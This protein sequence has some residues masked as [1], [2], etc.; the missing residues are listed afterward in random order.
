[1]SQKI[2]GVIAAG[3][4]KTAEAG[5]EMF[6]LGGNAFDA[7]IASILAAFVVESALTS[8]A[9]GGFLLAHTQDNRNILFDFFSQTPR[10]KKSLEA[11]N[12]YPIDVNFG[13]EMQAFHIGLGSIAVPGN[14]AGVFK[15]QQQLGRLPFDIV[16]QPAIHYAQ[17]GFQVSNFQ[18]FCFQLLEPILLALPEGK[19]IY[20]PNGNL[21]T[22]GEMC[23]MKDFARTLSQLSQEGIEDFY[24]GDI[25]HQL[26]KDC[27]EGGGYLTLEDLQNYQVIVRKP[28]KINYRDYELLTNPPPSSGGALIAF[29]LE[30]LKDINLDNIEFG[31]TEHLELLAQ[32]MCLTNE[33]RKDGYDKNIYQANIA[34]DF[35]AQEHLFTYQQKLQRITNKWGSTTHISVMDNEGNAA[36]VTTS[37]GEGSSYII[38]GTGIMLNNMLGEADLNPL[39]FHNWQCNQRISSMMSPTIVLDRGKPKLV[40]GSGGSNRIRNAILQVICNLLDFHQPIQTA[41]DNSRVHWENNIFSVEPSCNKEVLKNLVLPESNQLILWEEK[42][43]FFGGVNAVIKNSNGVMDGAG[44]PRREGIFVRF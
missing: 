42:N 12:F 34:K 9:G 44:D 27:Q 24:Q 1:M 3:H 5:Q 16:A 18:G 11:V 19:K 8:I 10:Q 28:L 43:M 6:A 20:A 13:G 35:L 7:A 32:V 39:G 37:N 14:L 23:F 33:G 26:V 22:T 36:S 38:P 21:L 17:N 40:L 15:V 4:K 41:V 31:S 2:R 30:L 29:A 25:A